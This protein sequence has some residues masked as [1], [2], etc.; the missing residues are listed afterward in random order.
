MFKRIALTLTFIAA[1]ST[2]A[3]SLPNQAEAWR[4][5]YGR[6]YAGAY[7]APRAVYYGPAVVPY[8]TYY[9]PRVVQPYYPVYYAPPAY[10][11]YYNSYYAAPAGV[12]VSF[13]Y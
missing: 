9:G 6:P 4:G 8:R 11:V 12:S 5:Y 10:P 2:I 3:I 7:Y 13:G 1:F